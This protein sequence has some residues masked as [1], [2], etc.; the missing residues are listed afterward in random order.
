MG[1]T[2]QL[3]FRDANPYPRAAISPLIASETD[4]QIRIAT[5]VVDRAMRVLDLGVRWNATY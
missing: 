5:S 2:V 4:Q 3:S 1:S